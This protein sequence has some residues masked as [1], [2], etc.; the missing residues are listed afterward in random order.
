MEPFMFF[1]NEVHLCAYCEETPCVDTHCE[2][3]QAELEACDTANDERDDA[4]LL[5]DD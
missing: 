3:C 1:D 5:G 4:A 2:T